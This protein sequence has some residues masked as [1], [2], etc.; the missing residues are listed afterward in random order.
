MWLTSHHVLWSPSIHI[1][2]LTQGQG[3]EVDEG[4]KRLDASETALCN[5]YIFDPNI[6]SQFGCFEK[7]TIISYKV[8][9]LQSA[10]TQIHHKTMDMI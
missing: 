3:F 9:I 7:S 1:L 2:N 10:W 4:D 6:I 5:D 8:W